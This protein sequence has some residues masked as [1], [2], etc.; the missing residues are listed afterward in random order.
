MVGLTATNPATILSFAALFASIRAGT[1][2]P[3]G[4]TLVVLGVF[5]G[6]VGWWAILT[7]VT[8]GL[9][10]RLTPPIIR[11]LNVGSALV[12]GAFGVAAIV[13]GITR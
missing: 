12:I 5:T 2:G 6:S 9:R 13:F 7:G 8:A 11:G 4:A 3:G 1:D 10:T